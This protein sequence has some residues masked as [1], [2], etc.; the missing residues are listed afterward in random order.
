MGR[1]R[2]ALSITSVAVTGGVLGTPVKWESS[3]EKAA[4]EQALAMLAQN[5]QASRPAG[6]PAPPVAAACCLDCINQGCDARF[7]SKVEWTRSAELC[8]CLRHHPPK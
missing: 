2:K 1:I 5:N 6:P 3:A 4:R 8:G 7:G